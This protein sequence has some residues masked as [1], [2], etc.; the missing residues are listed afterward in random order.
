MMGFAPVADRPFGESLPGRLK[1]GVARASTPPGL[2]RS[3]RDIPR[4]SFTRHMAQLSSLPC[5]PNKGALTLTSYEHDFI[6][7]NKLCGGPGVQNPR[8]VQN[9]KEAQ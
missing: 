8:R 3:R 2:T 7:P 5:A 1:P 9:R 6:W 4:R